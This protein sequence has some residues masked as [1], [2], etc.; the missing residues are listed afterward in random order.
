MRHRVLGMMVAGIV[1]AAQ[2]GSFAQEVFGDAV[3][4]QQRVA[5]DLQEVLRGSAASELVP[6]TI[7]MTEQAPREAVQTIFNF[8]RRSGQREAMKSFLKPIAQRTQTELLA[9]LHNEQSLGSVGGNIRS[10]WIHNMVGAEMTRD[11]A[12]HV[13]QRSDVAHLYLDHRIGKEM[14]P[15]QGGHGGTT[16]E[17]ECGVSLMRAPEVWNDFGNTGTGVVVGVIDT[18][19]CIT[20]PDLVNQIWTNP[21]ETPNNG[22]DDDNNGYIDDI[23]G[24]NFEFN[25]ND[26][27]D[28]DRGG[29]GTHVTGTVVGDG[30]NGTQTGMAPTAK[31]M[32]VRIYNHVGSRGEQSVWDSMQYCVD[33]GADVMVGVLGFRHGANPQ[34]SVW[35]ALCENA[36]AAG[37][38]VTFTAAVNG[39]AYGIDS[40]ETPGDVPL[41][42]TVGNTDC[43]DN[44]M[45][46]SSRGPVSWEGIDPYNDWP[47]PPG[48]MKPTVT[49]PGNNT[50]ST[51]S[52]C[53]GYFNQ[54]PSAT[55]HVAGTIALMLSANPELT[56]AQVRQLLMSTSVDLG[57]PGPDNEYGAGRVDAYEAVVAAMNTAGEIYIGV[58]SLHAGE[59][60]RIDASNC[61]PRE[62]VYFV[63]SLHG[64]G[65]T[66]VRQL[67]V[68]LDL[69]QPQLI[70]S[71]TADRYGI[72][73][74]SGFVSNGLQGR[75]VWVQ[76]AQQSK[77]SNVV[78]HEVQ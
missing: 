14:F 74:V 52:N 63:A 11:V 18:G 1:L 2:S 77:K 70:A 75:H 41:V 32:I 29:H 19:C 25:N 13:A 8:E 3:Q 7:V 67:N 28:G 12:M 20:H 5:P 16:A 68:T 72:A 6:I 27:S 60:A 21:N 65:S 64:L 9:Y 38:V 37:V 40:V 33:N 71:K 48:K 66:Y 49:A 47:Y 35:R 57:D 22:I 34:R 23:H 42:I 31:A 39:T 30:T 26:V 53:T 10:F 56:H 61:N 51:S 43:S 44:L 46:W 15:D 78:T 59:L 62:R 4:L 36:M 50:R 76:A 17:I 45:I 54:S 69:A 73:G 24:W 55:P 58:E